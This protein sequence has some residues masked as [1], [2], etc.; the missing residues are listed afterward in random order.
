M[1]ELDPKSPHEVPACSVVGA[2]RLGTV[3]AAALSEHPALRRG[4]PVPARAEVVLLCVPDGKI[5]EVAAAVAA[6]PAASG[7]APAPPGST[8]SAA[9]RASRCIR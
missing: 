1:R 9:A 8:S 6:R 2:G 5:A 4:E 3:L 7:T